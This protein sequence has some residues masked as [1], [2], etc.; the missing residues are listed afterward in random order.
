MIMKKLLRLIPFVLIALAGA[1]AFSACSDDD[2]QIV[3]NDQLPVI[4]KNF[5]GQYYPNATVVSVHK[6][7]SDYDVILSDGTHIDFDHSGNWTDVDAPT[8][9]TVAQG[10][11]PAAIDTYVS[12][13]YPSD[14]INEISKD[15]GNYDVD[16]ISGIDLVFNSDGTYVGID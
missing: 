4:A 9:K 3:G 16:L 13:N 10:F 6:D 15:K 5:L 14:G 7:K 12:A 8:G 1:A 11:Y 2:D